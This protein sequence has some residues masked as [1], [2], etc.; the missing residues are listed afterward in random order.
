[1]ADI[2]ATQGSSHVQPP[3]IDDFRKDYKLQ[4][5]A[6]VAEM[7]TTS[8][9]YT[10][11]SISTSAAFRASH[12]AVLN[13]SRLSSATTLHDSSADV[14]QKEQIEEPLPTPTHRAPESNKKDR[15]GALDRMLAR[16]PPSAWRMRGRRRERDVGDNDSEIPGWSDDIENGRLT[17]TAT[18]A[19][20]S[21]MYSSNASTLPP[22]YAEYD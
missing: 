11:A 5:H 17:R 16:E 14:N 19:S 21:T 3:T 10:L 4:V 15:R 18:H 9:T 22:P 12:E 6:S 7:D 13:A 8:D 2:I 1:M 20:Q